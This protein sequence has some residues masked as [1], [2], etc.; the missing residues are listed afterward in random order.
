MLVEPLAPGS[1]GCQHQ[2]RAVFEQLVHPLVD[3]RPA[4]FTRTGDVDAGE[5]A[6][7]EPVEDRLWG[8]AGRVIQLHQQDRPLEGLGYLEGQSGAFFERAFIEDQG[9]VAVAH[10]QPG[11]FGIFGRGGLAQPVFLWQGAIL[12]QP[13]TGAPASMADAMLQRPVQHRPIHAGLAAGDEIFRCPGQ[14]AEIQN[15][16]FVPR[17]RRKRTDLGDSKLVPVARLEAVRAALLAVIEAAA[18]REAVS[19][20]EAIGDPVARAGTV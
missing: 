10:V 7:P 9:G 15:M 2:R 6:L 8:I 18:L 17:R 12:G 20:A 1:A 14:R 4:G 11:A 3:S 16:G 19:L 13:A 5:M